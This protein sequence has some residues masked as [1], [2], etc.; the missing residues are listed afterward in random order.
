MQLVH[1]GVLSDSEFWAGRQSLLHDR[2]DSASQ[3]QGFVSSM[4]ASVQQSADGKSQQARI[5]PSPCLTFAVLDAHLKIW[6]DKF[7]ADLCACTRLHMA[8][9]IS[10]SLHPYKQGA[11]QAAEARSLQSAAIH[12]GR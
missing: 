3:R 2:S 1:G 5:R 6:S 9:L 10:S 12:G 7:G 4:I 8:V 11:V